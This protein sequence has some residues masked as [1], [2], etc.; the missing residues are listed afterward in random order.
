MGVALPQ[1]VPQMK[2]SSR[3]PADETHHALRELIQRHAAAHRD[4]ARSVEQV[5]NVELARLLHA[6]SEQHG[7]QAMELAGLTGT[8]DVRRQQLGR[9]PEIGPG[10]SPHRRSS[11]GPASDDET[12]HDEVDDPTHVLLRAEEAHAALA[13]RYE[14]LLRKVPGGL[15]DAVLR[16]HHRA[17]MTARRQ[18]R[19]MRDHWHGLAPNALDSR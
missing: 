1:P 6:L 9:E 12:A 13:K 16:E 18:T 14:A 3:I 8:L 15:L 5:Q 4:F 11:H 7:E 10:H 2:T 17:A 19:A